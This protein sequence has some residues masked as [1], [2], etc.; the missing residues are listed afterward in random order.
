M[1]QDIKAVCAEYLFATTLMLMCSRD[2]WITPATY[3]RDFAYCL[4]SHGGDERDIVGRVGALKF[5]LSTKFSN[6]RD[7]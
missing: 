3:G 5:K 4:K 1:G 6:E 7:V 2:D